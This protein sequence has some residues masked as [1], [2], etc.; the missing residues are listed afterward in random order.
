MSLSA[1]DRFEIFE[2]LNLHQRCIDNDGSLESVKKYLDLYW[3]NSKFT[4][5]DL[6]QVDFVGD[7]QLKQM[8]DYAH[9]VFPLH[10]WKHSFG[11]FHIEGAGNNATAHWSWI[12]SWREDGQGVVSTGEYKDRFEKR[13][14][15]WKCIERISTTDANWPVSLFQPYLDLQDETFKAS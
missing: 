12:V 9:S 3:P 4:V 10:K 11:A 2:Q 8:Y 6:R 14:G 13:N 7:E 5:N 15:I 1:T